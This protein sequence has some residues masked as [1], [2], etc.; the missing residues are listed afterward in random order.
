M[1]GVVRIFIGLQNQSPSARCEPADRVSNDK[2][3]KHYT[4]KDDFL[5]QLIWINRHCA[6]WIPENI[7]SPQIFHV[8][9][10]LYPD[11]DELVRGLSLTK[12]PYFPGASRLSC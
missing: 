9:V 5:L 3:A 6:F 8:Y 11:D 10:R 12:Q 1:K 4:T 7:S 2:H